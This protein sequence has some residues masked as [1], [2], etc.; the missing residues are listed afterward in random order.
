M[1][2]LVRLYLLK[3]VTEGVLLKKTYINHLSKAHSFLTEF[4]SKI[5]ADQGKVKACKEA[6]TTLGIND[7]T[8]ADCKSIAFICENV[9]SRAASL[10]SA[11]LATLL[12][13]MQL[14]NVTIGV[15]G[16][17]YKNHPFFRDMMTKKIKDLVEANLK[18]I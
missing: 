5:E 12:N 1:G 6:L 2:E 8:D 11:G 17:L 9:S 13:K 18:V 3:A 7:A 10:V 14:P 16:A 4:V 15:D